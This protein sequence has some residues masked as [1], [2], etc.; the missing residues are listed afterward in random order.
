MRNTK[1]KAENQFRRVTEEPFEGWKV[2]G[3]VTHVVLHG[4]EAFK[5]GKVLAEKSLGMDVRG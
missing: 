2:K 1:S 3:R 5:D 4:R